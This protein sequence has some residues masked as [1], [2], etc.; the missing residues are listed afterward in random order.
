MITFPHGENCNQNSKY[1]NVKV[2][3]FLHSSQKQSMAMARL[4]R[5]LKVFERSRA[6][7]HFC[8]FPTLSKSATKTSF[9]IQLKEMASIL[10]IY[11][12]VDQLGPSVYSS[13]HMRDTSKSQKPGKKQTVYA[14]KGRVAE[15][16]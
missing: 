12:L 7:L 4:P 15:P 5:E 16:K 6:F 10:E 3:S 13:I 11:R 2:S 8:I 9:K 1:A 14:H